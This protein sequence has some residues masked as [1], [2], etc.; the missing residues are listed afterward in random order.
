MLC[1]APA[2]E[3]K[4]WTRCVGVMAPSVTGCCSR[5]RGAEI[6]PDDSELHLRRARFNA[7]RPAISATRKPS[8]RWTC[9]SRASACWYDGFGR[10]EHPA[11]TRTVPGGSSPATR[12]V[13]YDPRPDRG[14]APRLWASGHRWENDRMKMVGAKLEL[15][16]L[17]M[18][19]PGGDR[20]VSS[21]CSTR[22][23]VAVDVRRRSSSRRQS[24]S[25][26]SMPRSGARPGADDRSR[27][28]STPGMS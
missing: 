5:T 15:R 22:R 18:V 3:L 2:L 13:V 16:I 20:D 27:A 24:A 8:S 17:S 4:P 6:P 19:R 11:R 25:A 9:G 12:E 14:G 28:T 10:P 7:R 23:L 26:P 21:A 1:P